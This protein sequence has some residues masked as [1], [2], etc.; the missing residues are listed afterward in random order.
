MNIHFL[1]VGYLFYGLV[2]GV[3]RPP[4][5]L[6]PI[7]KLG[8][9]LAAMPFHAF[10]GVILMT[11]PTPLAENFYRTLD[12]AWM[13]DLM[14]QQ[15]LGG[16]VAW[17]GGEL[18]LLIVIVALGIQWARQ[19]QREAKR[20]DRHLDTGVDDEFEA[21]NRMLA[22][23]SDRSARNSGPTLPTPPVKDRS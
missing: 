19:D 6:P 23:L 10:F 11:S 16:G 18:P 3:D 9:V 22:E 2:I 20:K 14:T 17:A 13:G 1:A 15:Y 21:Y 4:R 12:F 5:P 8:F 7:G